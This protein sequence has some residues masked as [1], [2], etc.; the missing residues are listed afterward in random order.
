MR[1]HDVFRSVP[2]VSAVA[3]ATLFGAAPVVATAAAPVPPDQMPTLSDIGAAA[4]HTADAESSRYEMYITVSGGPFGDGAG[5]SDTPFAVGVVRGT[6]TS[7]EM[8]L[9][10]L[11]EGMPGAGAL[12]GDMDLSMDMIGIGTDLYLHA[13]FY[14]LLAMGGDSVPPEVQVL[15][16]GWG[17]IDTE[18]VPG[19]SIAD[20]QSQTGTPGA[21]PSSY[22]SSLGKGTELTSVGV[23]S[24]GGVESV[25]VAMNITLGEMMEA[26]APAGEVTLDAEAAGQPVP[27]EVWIGSDGYIRRMVITMDSTVLAA[28]AEGQNTPT[29]VLDDASMVL[30]FDSF[31]FDDPTIEV[32]APKDFTD[33]TDFFA[34]AMLVGS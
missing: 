5:A 10:G 30:R 34:D 3:V 20:L 6:D 12:V 24:I 14:E 23:V 26:Q 28:T 8:D 31:D 2:L 32:A 15:V 33:V 18:R 22:L 16:D 19:L 13:P 11:F 7:I 25:G 29:S 27:L 1:R 21:S 4:D 9:T 17:Y